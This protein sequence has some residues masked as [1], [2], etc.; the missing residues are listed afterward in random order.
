ML[1]SAVRGM[2]TIITDLWVGSNSSGVS[3]KESL[4]IDN[5]AA[6]ASKTLPEDVYPDSGFRLPLPKRDDL[7]DYGKKVYD[8]TVGDVSRMVAG[9]R[10]SVGIPLYSPKLAEH[11]Y[12]LNQYLRY[13]SE[14]SGRIRELAILVTAQEIDSQF[15]WTAH[16]PIALKEGLPQEIIDIVKYRRSVANLSEIEEVIIQFG[17]QMF[18]QKK[19]NSETF[20]RALK[21]FG[22]KELVDLVALMANY[23]A[24]AAELCAFDI[25]LGPNQKPLLPLP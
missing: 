18:S 4:T 3:S 8:K 12:A 20:A 25:Q 5:G 2:V 14:F 24:V 11:E 16:E 13:E 7:D 17:R 6:Q 19:V 10:G 1:K 21:I 22:S 15:G 9:L 23:S